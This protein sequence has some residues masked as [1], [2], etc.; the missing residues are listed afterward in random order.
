ML[1]RQD[2]CEGVAEGALPV[3]PA[4]AGE[5]RWAGS[6]EAAAFKLGLLPAPC[7]LQFGGECKRYGGVVCVAGEACSPKLVEVLGLVDFKRPGLT[8]NGENRI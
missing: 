1:G 3:T 4:G 5:Q 6:S 2:V 7:Q 8:A